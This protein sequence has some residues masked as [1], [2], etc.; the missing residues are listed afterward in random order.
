MA[1]TRNTCTATAWSSS[2]RGDRYPDDEACGFIQDVPRALDN[3]VFVNSRL[4]EADRTLLCDI[5]ARTA[6]RKLLANLPAPDL[7]AL[8]QHDGT[9][10]SVLFSD[11]VA[12]PAGL[13]VGPGHGLPFGIRFG[14]G[15][16]TSPPRSSPS[17]AATAAWARC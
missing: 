13:L 15:V 1:R 8:I 14:I 10:R 4:W 3:H 5:D 7:G 6:V 12:E 16:P 11:K 9:P 2:S 17:S